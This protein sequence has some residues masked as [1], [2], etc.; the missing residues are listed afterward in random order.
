M[1]GETIRAAEIRTH[2]RR[3][4][5]QKGVNPAFYGCI[6]LGAHI[7]VGD[8][9]VSFAVPLETSQRWLEALLER[10]RHAADAHLAEQEK[11]RKAALSL[12]ERLTTKNPQPSEGAG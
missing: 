5:K 8:K 12:V 2:I 3:V 9:V 4:M 7:L 11:R 6:G 1:I 10:V